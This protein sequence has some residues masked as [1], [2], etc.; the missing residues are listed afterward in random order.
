MN[1]I[2]IISIGIFTFS[3]LLLASSCKKD[4]TDDP[5]PTNQGELI[6]TVQLIFT[7]TITGL[8]VDSATFSD[9]D[10]PGGVA[11]TQDSILLQA[12]RVYSTE[13]ILL[14]E[15]KNPVE[16]ISDEVAA[17]SDVHLFVF[18]A[19]PASGFLTTT[20]S[21]IDVNGQPVGLESY[22][23]AG[24]SATG[25]YTLELRHFDSAALKQA[26]TSYETDVQVTFGVR[27]N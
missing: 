24:S 6:T 5:A 19:A 18:T 12:G 13:V 2:K 26:N 14:D 22:L 25:S 11:P 17:E 23:V 1:T 21:D 9:P 3:I 20:I 8:V 7:D 15:S 10:G 4:K 27:L 16:N